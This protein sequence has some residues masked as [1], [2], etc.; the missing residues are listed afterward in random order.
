MQINSLDPLVGRSVGKYQ[1]EQRIGQGKLGTIYLAHQLEQ[2]HTVMMTV[3]N[4]PESLSAQEHE[5][6]N[7]RFVQE[8]NI[9]VR[10]THPNIIPTYDFG[11]HSGHPYL[12]TAFVKEASLGQLLKQQ[13]RFTLQQ[14][15]DI[16]KPVAS[17]L[18]YAHSHAI[19][20]DQ[21][22]LSML[23]NQGQT[24][25]I[26]GFGL[27]TIF[28]V[29]RDIQSKQLHSSAID[30]NGNF[31]RNTVYMS[32]EY[33]LG[34]PTDARSDIYA[35]GMILFELLSGSLPFSG[36]NPS[37]TSLKSTPSISTI[38]PDIPEALDLV[39]S[40]ALDHDP[41]KRY[42][43]ASDIVAAFEVLVKILGTSLTG[44]ASNT[45]KLAQNPQITLPP[46]VN[47][48][49]EAITLSG[50]LQSITPSTPTGPMSA[51]ASPS[52]KRKTA[53]DSGDVLSDA[54]TEMFSWQDEASSP[55]GNN[56][57][58]IAGV[59][60]FSWWSA[61]QRDASSPRPVSRKAGKRSSAGP[62]WKPRRQNR[63]RV[64]SIIATA[65]A[66]VTIGALVVEGASAINFIRGLHHSPSQ[67]ADMSSTESSSTTSMTHS[68]GS[69]PTAQATHQTPTPSSTSTPQPSSMSSASTQASSVPKQAPPV[70]KQAPTQAPPSHT[71]TVIG[72]TSQ[73]TNSSTTFTNPADGQ[74][75]L[76]IRLP[77]GNFVA[78][79]RACTH[80]GA[81]VNYNSSN[82][83]L[84]CPAHGAIFDPSNGFSHVSGPGS[85][86]LTAVS[87]RVNAD[88]TITTG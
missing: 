56:P 55:T 16:L 20:H 18:D 38:C 39:I 45:Q 17:A 8:G 24:I 67:A 4:L 57:N 48:F 12:A 42:Q 7:I 76:L 71:G 50:K 32:P 52:L 28:N 19:G 60:P 49:D 43:C 29:Y 1:I 75:C 63:R 3:F 23:I 82:Q 36:A 77:N 27:R 51:V 85:G 68:Q 22:S 79:E 59:D 33:A 15:L 34:M 13:G 88:G 25:Q 6:F 74:G 80:R 40:K 46:T 37:E 31:L 87:I 11:E 86:P 66:T 69:T 53:Q 70:P 65:A 9:L 30:N 73:A 62:S 26:A 61:T 72:Y 21:L 54:P 5:Q 64:V 41:E 58:S 81:A 35:L 47:W 84:V 44:I 83:Q 78:A 14:T 10:F 2:N